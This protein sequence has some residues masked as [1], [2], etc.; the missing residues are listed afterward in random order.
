MIPSNYL[1]YIYLFLI[2][3]LTGIKTNAQTAISGP[4]IKEFGKVYKIEKQDFKINTSQDFHVVF[5]VAKSPEEKDIKNKWIETAARFLNMHAQ[6]GV[7]LDNM[8][9]A[10][11]LHGSAFK[12]V[13]SNEAYMK[14]YGTI[15]PN[16]KLNTALLKANVQII[17]CGQS[18]V[19]RELK[20]EDLIPGVQLS[21]SAMTAL[22][23]LQNQ[24]YRL[25]NF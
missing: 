9:V 20:K 23:Q 5:D 17:L 2:I 15:N 1:K 11:V 8:K 13:M 24:N 19:Y 16:E 3:L 22:I 6:N 12:D 21:L 4:V 14:K 10:L 25:I 7:S 18:A